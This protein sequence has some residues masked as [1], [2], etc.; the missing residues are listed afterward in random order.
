MRAIDSEM[1]GREDATLS[2]AGGDHS[3]RRCPLPP[4]AERWRAR[5]WELGSSPRCAVGTGRLREMSPSLRCHLC[6]SGRL[7]LRRLTDG[8]AGRRRLRTNSNLHRMENKIDR[9]VSF[10]RLGRS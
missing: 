3:T 7:V 2:H 9:G 8:C 6:F 1:D 5:R 4:A 10:L